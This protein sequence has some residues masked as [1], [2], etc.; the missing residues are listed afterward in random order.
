MS[1]RTT[2][3]YRFMSISGY[4]QVIILLTFHSAFIFNTYQTNVN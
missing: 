4:M 1:I 3:K 2:V